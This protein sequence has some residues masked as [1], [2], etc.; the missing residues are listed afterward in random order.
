MRT[1]CEL[2]T[3]GPARDVYA[4]DVTERS[5]MAVG[6]SLTAA[7][8]GRFLP[9]LGPVGFCRRGLFHNESCR[10][11]SRAQAQHEVVRCRPG[12]VTVCGGPGSAVHRSTSFRAA[13]HP[14]HV[15]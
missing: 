8:L 13:P 10:C 1:E 11:V 15:A 7:P 9:R 6:R 12:T 3:L 2:L 5:V 4:G 14:G